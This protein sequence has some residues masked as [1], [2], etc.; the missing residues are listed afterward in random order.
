M[1]PTLGHASS[2]PEGTR[3]RTSRSLAGILFLFAL[4]FAGCIES[5][6]GHHH[7]GFSGNQRC[8]VCQVVHASADAPRTVALAQVSLPENPGRPADVIRVGPASSHLVVIRLRAPP[9]A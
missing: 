1:H 8:T 7:D 4:L 6:A 9:E 5:F 2:P 3:T